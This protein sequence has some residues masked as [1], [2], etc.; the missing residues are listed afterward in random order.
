MP[1]I[2]LTGAGEPP[3]GPGPDAVSA[4]PAAEPK[5]VLAAL[6]EV[7]AGLR[8]LKRELGAR[9]PAPSSRPASGGPQGADA[10]NWLDGRR[11]SRSRS[12]D[13]IGDRQVQGDL[14]T[15]IRA[16][17]ANA[18]LS[19][20]EPSPSRD[21]RQALEPVG[22]ITASHR[23]RERSETLEARAATRERRQGDTPPEGLREAFGSASDL[24]RARRLR[25]RSERLGE[26][27]ELD[28]GRKGYL[29]FE[30]TARM[31]LRENAAR[32]REAQDELKGARAES[33]T[34]Q[35]TEAL[36][37]R[38]MT[39]EGRQRD[40]AYRQDRTAAEYENS[41]R[42]FIARKQDRARASQEREAERAR[43]ATEQ[44]DTNA[45]LG[46][47]RR[48]GLGRWVRDDRSNLGTISAIA[49]AGQ[50]GR[51][52]G[53]LLGTAVEAAEA[54]IESP[55]VVS[56]LMNKFVSGAQPYRDLMFSS[57]ALG[58]AGGYDGGP[59]SE[60]WTPTRGQDG[61]WRKL[62]GLSTEDLTS[63][64]SAYGA[65]ARSAASQ[66]GIVAAVADADLAPKLGGLGKT[67]Y[68]AMLGTA[69]LLGLKGDG[70]F[71]Q[72]GDP[73][74][75]DN[76]HGGAA[77]G[78]LRDW[79]RTMTAAVAAGMDRSVVRS[80]IEGLMRQSA[81][82]GAAEI[83]APKTADA[84]FRMA[85][86]GSPDARTG[87]EQAG[88]LQGM[89]DQVNSGGL[90]GGVVPNAVFHSYLARHGG[91]P[92][93]AAGVAKLLGVDPTSMEPG[94]RRKF[95][96]VVQAAQSGNEAVTFE[97]A[98]PF[99][100][101]NQGESWKSIVDG[102]GITPR[103]PMHDLIASRLRGEPLG[104]Y[105]DEQAGQ[106]RRPGSKGR[107]G[108]GD[109]PDDV[110]RAIYDASDDTK[111]DSS[112]LAGL[113]SVESGFDNSARSGR[114]AVGLGQITRTAITDLTGG[115]RGEAQDLWERSKTDPSLNAH[116]SARYYSKLR[117]RYGSD[118]EALRHYHGLQVDRNG[119]GP[120]QY[121]T[122]VEASEASYQN[123]PHRLR[124]VTTDQSD[125]N[126]GAARQDETFAEGLGKMSDIV[127]SWNEKVNEGTNAV[128]KWTAALVKSTAA[129]AGVT[130]SSASHDLPVHAAAHQAHAARLGWQQLATR[131]PLMP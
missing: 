62:R 104:A 85:S 87:D 1:Q 126:Q 53:G 79:Q 108:I 91:L 103:G 115:D 11:T 44:A 88:A 96:D 78:Y 26:K 105:Q 63:I 14:R 97:Y 31:H 95:D 50:A 98:K 64:S 6:K 69:Q 59:L 57:T 12:I 80:S 82:S 60:M 48:A 33:R 3:D 21:L 52:I 16:Y 127:V 128:V 70:V 54:V 7:S 110:R 43:K 36:K 20:A 84:W 77:Y 9:Q 101:A 72:S 39:A 32:E 22:G 109:V 2:N 18:R 76:R 107:L 100:Y 46:R 74:R 130:P 8:D 81:S 122:R 35:Q 113:F 90:S 92:R 17:N 114:G 99:L 83:N 129:L 102:S 28:A 5:S 125:M 37:R 94:E 24:V 65:P 29:A 116:L 117:D 121:A 89:T 41:N 25:E 38:S 30:A 61:D 67:T 119:V 111:V 4:T 123:D 120:D 40:R 23:L 45:K 112:I 86:S 124:E 47:V 13:P 10:S 71:G 27:A 15:S 34:A 118:H 55:R 131:G 51:A 42:D 68:A 75:T 58:R 66:N 93:D 19:D 56:G 73:G 49:P 106:R